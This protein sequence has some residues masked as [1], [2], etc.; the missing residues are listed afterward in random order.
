VPASSIVGDGGI[1][2]PTTVGSSAAGAGAA[3]TAAP[4]FGQKAAPSGTLA[5]QLVQV[6]SLT[7]GLLRSARA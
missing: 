2:V 6:R 7:G 3:A 5:P 4:Q 1:G